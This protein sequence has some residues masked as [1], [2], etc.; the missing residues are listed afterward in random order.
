MG[1]GRRHCRSFSHVDA[2]YWALMLLAGT[3]GTVIGDAASFRSGLGLPL[4]SLVL[5]LVTALVLTA[6]KRAWALAFFYWPVI[7]LVRA[8]GTSVGDFFAHTMG[9]TQS[10]LFFSILLIA[11]VAMWKDRRS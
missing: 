11:L 5:T 9:L 2:A 3:L 10:T 6:G 7:V 8:A 1:H 4:A